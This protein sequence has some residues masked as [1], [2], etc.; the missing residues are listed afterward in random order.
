MPKLISNSIIFHIIIEESKRLTKD[1]EEEQYIPAKRKLIVIAKNAIKRNNY[2]YS[3]HS[4]II[5]STSSI[6][7]YTDIHSQ[8]SELQLE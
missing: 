8:K 4:Y 6:I 3:V 2:Y 7:Q 1:M 5:F